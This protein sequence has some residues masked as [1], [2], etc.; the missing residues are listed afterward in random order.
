VA[1]LEANEFIPQFQFSNPYCP[2]SGDFAWGQ[3]F[4]ESWPGLAL[5]GAGL[6]DVVPGLFGGLLGGAAESDGGSL[7][8]AAQAIRAGLNVGATRN[9]A[10]ATYDIDGAS[11]ELAAVSGQAS[12]AGTAGIPENPAF[13]PV[14][15]SIARPLDAEYKLLEELA[16]KAT[17]E[18][19]GVVNLYSELPVCAACSSVIEQ[20]QKAY[21]GISVHLNS[22]S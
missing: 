16:S 10:I 1:S 6:F 5:G 15:G 11:G 21:P 22:G 20:F 12:R 13:D 18:S 17:A 8:S 7:A 4:G 19:T 9:V 2:D 3:L 14:S